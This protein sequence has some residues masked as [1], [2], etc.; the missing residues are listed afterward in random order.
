MAKEKLR[1][2][3]DTGLPENFEYFN[4]AWEGGPKVTYGGSELNLEDVIVTEAAHG[5]TITFVGDIIPDQQVTYITVFIPP[6]SF[7]DGNGAI[8]ALSQAVI[9]KRSIRIGGG[10]PP[11]GQVIHYESRALAGDAEMQG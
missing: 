11:V 9:S 7:S 8:Y 6:L 5:S 3:F 1:Y 4:S 10:S 2:R